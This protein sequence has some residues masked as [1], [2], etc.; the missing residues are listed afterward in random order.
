M[1]VVNLRQARK[2]KARQEKQAQA[3]ENRLRYGRS[4]A[5][6]VLEEEER[7]KAEKQQDHHRLTSNESKDPGSQ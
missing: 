3:A 6:K 7:S 4:K 2:A 5:R 1:T